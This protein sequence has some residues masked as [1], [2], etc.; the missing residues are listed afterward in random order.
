MKLVDEGKGSELE[1]ALVRAMATRFVYP[2]TGDV[3]DRGKL[4][5]C[6]KEAMYAV[7]E[8]F[9]DH[10][11]V[12]AIYAESLMQLSPWNMYDAETL[13]PNENCVTVTRVRLSSFGTVLT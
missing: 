8:Q 6:F 4:D 2:F 13:M 3:G 11:E 7:Y 10:P 9:P 12:T 5:E 1:Q